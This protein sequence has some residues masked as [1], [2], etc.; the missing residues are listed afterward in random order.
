M[1]F[2][3]IGIRTYLRCWRIGLEIKILIS[4]LNVW[5]QL[6]HGSALRLFDKEFLMIRPVL[7]WLCKRAAANADMPRLAPKRSG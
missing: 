4:D 3:E 1:A 2:P 5:Q 7:R 6:R